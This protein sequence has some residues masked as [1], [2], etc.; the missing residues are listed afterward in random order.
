MFVAGYGH[1]ENAVTTPP[2]AGTPPQR[3]LRHW[4]HR[5]HRWTSSRGDQGAGRRG[6]GLDQDVRL[7]GERTANVT[8]RADVHR[9]KKCALPRC[10]GAPVRQ[11][12][13]HSLVRR[14]R[15]QR[16]AMRAGA[17]S[18]EHPAGLD[19]A[20]LAEFAKRGTVLCTD[21]STTTA[22]TPRTLPLLGYTAEASRGAGFLPH[23]E[24]RNGA[25]RRSK[26]A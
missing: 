20:T 4:G 18:V 6:R 1:V 23:P 10:D 22:F 7:D 25:A 26:P 3:N 17:E 5:R 19:D 12:D 9:M 13:R 15:R 14:F 2:R 16:A 21:R 24:P 8:G 11:E